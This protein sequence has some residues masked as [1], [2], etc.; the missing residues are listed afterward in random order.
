MRGETSSSTYNQVQ[1]ALTQPSLDKR[2]L[3][4]IKLSAEDLHI[5]HEPN[6]FLSWTKTG[7]VLSNYYY[8][9]F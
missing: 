3:N 5:V 4:D 6:V 2:D 1:S 9:C 7:E 8:Y